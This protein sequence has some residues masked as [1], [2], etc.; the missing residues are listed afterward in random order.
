MIEVLAFIAALRDLHPDM[1]HWGLNGGCF[2]VYL[3]LKQRFPQ[4]EPWYNCSHVITKIGDHFYD[5]RGEVQPVSETSAPF[6]P[7]DALVFNRAYSWEGP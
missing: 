2:R 4:A 3:V 7:M 1:P 6:I 5:I